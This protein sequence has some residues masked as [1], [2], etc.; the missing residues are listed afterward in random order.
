VNPRYPWIVPVA[1]VVAVIVLL[2][3]V[4]FSAANG[5]LF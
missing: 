2:G 5:M 4:V 3:V 1:V